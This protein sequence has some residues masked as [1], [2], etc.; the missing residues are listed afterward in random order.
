MKIYGAKQEGAIRKYMGKPSNYR[1]QM[2]A[3]MEHRRWCAEYLLKG[4]RPLNTENNY[5]TDWF[6]GKKKYWKSQKRHLDL[7]PF[8]KLQPVIGYVDP[9][10]G[11]QEPHKDKAQITFIL[12]EG[13]SE[14][15][16]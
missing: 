9:I 14:S 16:L 10:Q 15:P 7:M 2:L 3:R 5:I 12:D 1:I 13:N 4:F 11:A 8:D 6:S